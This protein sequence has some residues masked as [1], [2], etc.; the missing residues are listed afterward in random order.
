MLMSYGRIR[1]SR[2]YFLGLLVSPGRDGV[3]LFCLGVLL[4]RV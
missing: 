2:H 4:A 3:I 1:G